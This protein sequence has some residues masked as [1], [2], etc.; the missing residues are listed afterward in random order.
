MRSTGTTR[1]REEGGGKGVGKKGKGG[2]GAGKKGTEEVEGGEG[3]GESEAAEE[4]SVLEQLAERE[5][6]DVICL[7]ET[8][9]QIYP[10]NYGGSCHCFSFDVVPIGGKIQPKTI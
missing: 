6:A 8:K 10:L 4:A 2:R 1:A 9:A 5:G 3:G 7:Q